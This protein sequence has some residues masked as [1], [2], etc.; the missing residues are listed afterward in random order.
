MIDI[1]FGAMA[2]AWICTLQ[3]V[4]RESR[5]RSSLASM[6]RQVLGSGVVML[7]ALL[8]AL[9]IGALAFDARRI[10]VLPAVLFA[11]ALLCM[12]MAVIRNHRRR[13]IREGWEATV[14]ATILRG[15]NLTEEPVERPVVVTIPAH[16]AK[17]VPEHYRIA[18]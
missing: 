6:N 4:D 10:W 14:Q 17:P 8:P 13:A 3:P 2:L 16:V 7:A 11:A 18:A 12:A 15:W 5:L 1:M 9:R